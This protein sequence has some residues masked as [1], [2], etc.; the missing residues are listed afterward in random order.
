VLE[1][2]RQ[3]YAR[4]AE[5]VSLFLS[6]RHDDL[7]ARLG[8]QMKE[9]AARLAFEVAAIYRNQL[10][11][12][13][14]LRERQRVVL[15]SDV[16]Q[17]VLGLY[18]E[19]DLAELCVVYV[20]QGRVVE[21]VSVSHART[22][23][24]DDELV[25][26]FLRD[27]YTEGGLGSG[28]VPDEVLV[29]TL[30][31]GAEGVEEWL[32]ERREGLRL[33]RGESRRAGRALLLAPQRGPK[34]KLLE[35]AAENAAHAFAEKR[36]KDEDMDARLLEVQQKLRLPALPRRIECCDISH[37][38]G[39]ATVGS[40]VAL[41]DG[42]P[43]KR[44]YKAYRVRSVSDGDDYAALFEVLSR[45]FLR[46]ASARLEQAA[47]PPVGEPPAPG[48]ATAP[49]EAPVAGAELPEPKAWALPDLFIVDGGRG[50]LG[51]ALA[52]AADLGLSD[53]P[54]VGLAKERETVGGERLV[55]RVY[56]PGQKNPIP[57]R[58]H[59]PELFLLARARDEAHRFANVQ[60]ERIGKRRRFT[61]ALDAVPGVGPKLRTRLL[62]RFGSVS[63][64]RDATDDELRA[65]SGVSARV[66]AALRQALGA[67]APAAEP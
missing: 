15:V 30:P 25:A 47:A 1:V 12:V 40:I 3:E 45:R 2:D 28:N 8:E 65:V 35:L 63:A 37:L 19:G 17:D 18:R 55:D 67:Q 29:P 27:H 10:D 20:R 31:E 61:S 38:G 41:T 21:I 57:L 56:L 48:E 11:A 7:S 52:V 6:G 64:L 9:A 42:E 14:K 58:P 22:S 23:L 16:D 34:K 39:E 51:V 54:I 62:E 60:R 43:D 66:L 44:R 53:L 26:A 50:Q 13:G 49:A 33:E 46:G 59:T 32:S 5:S 36:R 4:Q 24:P